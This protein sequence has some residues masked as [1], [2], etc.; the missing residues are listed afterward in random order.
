MSAKIVVLIPP[1]RFPTIVPD[2]GAWWSAMAGRHDATR[3]SANA[4][5]WKALC[6]PGGMDA[7]AP[8][9]RIQRA[10][11]RL[12]RI[13]QDVDFDF[14]ES[15]AQAG[16][17][18]RS[19]QRRSS[20]E[21]GAAYASVMAPLAEHLAKL[22]QAQ[23]EL[24]F[25]L[26][27]GVSVA[28]LDYGDSAS[29][30]QYAMKDTS[31]SRLITLA[32]KDATLDISFL[33]VTVTCPEDLLTAMIAVRCMKEARPGMHASLIDHGYENFSL[34]AHMPSLRASG[35]LG[36]IFDSI[37][38]SR[39]DRDALVPAL[40]ELASGAAAPKGFL[41][42]ADVPAAA[43]AHFVAPPPV[44]TF[45]SEP[46]FWTRLSERPCYWSRCAFCV[47]NT[48]YKDQRPP[49][50]AEIGQALDRIRTLVNAGYGTLIFSD[51]AVSPAFLGALSAGILERG[52]SFRWA[53]RSKLELALTPELFAQMRAAG[54]REVLFGLETTSPR[55]QKRMDKFTE[56]LDAAAIRRILR[57]LS[58]AGIGVHVNM[59]AGFPGDT[60]AEAEETVE[61]VVEALAEMRGATFSFNRFELFPTTPI[62]ADPGRFGVVPVPASGDMPTSYRYTVIPEFHEDA[63]AV[64]RQFQ[65]L[66]A[67]LFAGLGWDRVSR[68][69]GGEA[70]LSLY[71]DSGHGALFKANPAS[72]FVNPLQKAAA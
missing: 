68:M 4:D 49:S 64:D 13:A 6:S 30:L 40:T 31:L 43:P 14:E 2:P 17:A 69:P 47:Q 3:L 9:S 62:H 55:M 28:G 41:T 22:N 36:R 42:R 48:K 38:E 56:G 60:L 26:A 58:D 24:Q 72:P 12:E 27:H 37:I 59:I 44:E 8:R 15:A 19:L 67:K 71:F 18:L 57:S 70:A 61:F 45:S 66:R 35:R 39:E 50:R 51:E 20:Y 53:C 23:G 1:G 52:L 7:L 32:V 29:L 54:C 21:S 63:V 16:R 11:R 34:H 46:V 65:R 25:S 5:W 10:W 33:A